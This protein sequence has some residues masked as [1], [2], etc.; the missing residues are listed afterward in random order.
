MKWMGHKTG[1]DVILEEMREA[2]YRVIEDSQLL[3]RQSF[4]VFTPAAQSGS[5]EKAGSPQ[6]SREASDSGT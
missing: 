1:K 6:R 2:G 4:I 3:D 5:R